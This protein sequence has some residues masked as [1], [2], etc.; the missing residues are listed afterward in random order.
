MIEYKIKEKKDSDLETI[1]EK[2]GLT[3]D[4]T[5]QQVIDHLEFTRKV[6][7][8]TEA[9][10]EAHK[11]QDKMAIEIIPALAELPIEKMNLV[12]AYAGRQLQRETSEN[13]IETSKKTIAS[14]E[15]QLETIQ[16]KLGLSLEEKEE[17]AEEEIL[18]EANEETTENE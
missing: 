14:Y 15:E 3:V 2:S 5:L 17:E 10:L 18:E 13:L 8:E 9:Q 1:I 11:I 4:F 12:S 7:R 6:L 16:E